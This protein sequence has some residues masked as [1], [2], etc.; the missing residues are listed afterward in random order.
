MT[1]EEKNALKQEIIDDLK[2]ESTDITE[3]EST[4]SLDGLTSLPAMQD[5]KMVLAPIG[6]LAQ[7]AI[8]AAATANTA[9]SN[10][11]AAAEGA[12]AAKDAANTAASEANAAKEA[13]RTAAENANAA[14]ENAD[15]IVVLSDG[16]VSE[17]GT[18]DEL[19]RK[20]GLYAKLVT[21]QTEAAQWK[22]S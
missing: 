21:L 19:M 20:N 14:A 3:L 7:P 2:N 11:S 8:D 1:D 4:T 9:A 17:C 16:V 5:S 18:H 10:A 13:A 15:K 6:A 22:I 12:N